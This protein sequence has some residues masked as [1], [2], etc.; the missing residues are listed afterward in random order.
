MLDN[1]VQSHNLDK[2][3]TEASIVQA[4]SEWEQ[5]SELIGTLDA[6]F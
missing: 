2:N 1:F 4:H 3:A 5:L 6:R